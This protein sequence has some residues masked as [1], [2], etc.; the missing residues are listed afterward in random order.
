M[1][2]EFQ[3]IMKNDVWEV[4]PKPEGKS[5]VASKW[6]FKI[7]QKGTIWTQANK[8]YSYKYSIY[9]KVKPCVG[10]KM[11]PSALHR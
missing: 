7:Q 2:E 11:A 10:H 5:I 4:V 6:L 3:S 1:M 8:V 9:H